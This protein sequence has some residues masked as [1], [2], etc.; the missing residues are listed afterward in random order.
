MT[1]KPPSAV[2]EFPPDSLEK[3]AYESVKGIPTQEPND[4]HRLG[5]QVW[6]WLKER[7]GTLDDVVKISGCRTNLTVAEVVKEIGAK[8]ESK[9]VSLQ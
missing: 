1:T 4:Q 9:G 3:I 2:Q 6:I 8:L 7:R 5:Y